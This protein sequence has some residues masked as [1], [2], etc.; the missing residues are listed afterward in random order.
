VRVKNR[1]SVGDWLE[2]IHPLGNVD[3]QLTRMESGS[4]EAIDVAPG[5]GHTVWLP[6]P[7]SAVGAFVARYVN[8]P[9]AQAPEALVSEVK[10]VLAL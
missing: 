10:G 8:A 3:V 5:S 9:E 4:A 1:F 2:I 7:E 6:L